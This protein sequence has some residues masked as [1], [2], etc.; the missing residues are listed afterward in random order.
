M[1]GSLFAALIPHPAPWETEGGPKLPRN[2]RCEVQVSAV[3]RSSRRKRNGYLTRKLLK[4]LSPLQRTQ[5]ASKV[6]SNRFGDPTWLRY[7]VLAMENSLLL[8]NAEAKAEVGG[9]L[10][11]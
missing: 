8:E 2:T 4:I 5:L 7:R 6:V 11:I 9:G 1:S 3:G 10:L